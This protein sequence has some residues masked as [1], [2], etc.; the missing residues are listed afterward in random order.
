MSLGRQLPPLATCLFVAA[1]V[2]LLGASRLSTEWSK[3]ARQLMIRSIGW[4]EQG[5][6]GADAILQLMRIVAAAEQDQ[7]PGYDI[8]AD[9]CRSIGAR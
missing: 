9:L 5:A 7:R 4:Q 8:A 3:R 1:G 2:E 6:L